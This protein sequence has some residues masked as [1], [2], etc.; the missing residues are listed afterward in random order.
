ML[1]PIHETESQRSAIEQPS[2]LTTKGSIWHDVKLIST[3]WEA[4]LS[5]TG[6]TSNTNRKGT[7]RQNHLRRA[8]HVVSFAAPLDLWSA[9]GATGAGCGAAGTPLLIT[10]QFQDKP[11][12]CSRRV[13]AIIERIGLGYASNPMLA[14]ISRTLQFFFFLIACVL[15]ILNWTELMKS[16]DIFNCSNLYC[17]LEV[18]HAKC[19]KDGA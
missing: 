6:F 17:I 7:A 8:G 1:S 15:L 14:L 5:M 9:K 11:C 18:S 10:H 4:L 13:A 2:A 12:R 16:L 3:M 19:L